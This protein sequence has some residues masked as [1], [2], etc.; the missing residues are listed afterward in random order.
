MST[1]ATLDALARTATAIADATTAAVKAVTYYV[2]GKPA[3]LSLSPA[4][5]AEID[6]FMQET[7]LTTSTCAL[8]WDARPIACDESAPVLTLAQM[9]EL[10]DALATTSA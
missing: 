5:E 10:T 4:E 9:A 8:D 2:K 3:P 6:Q 1:L 7:D